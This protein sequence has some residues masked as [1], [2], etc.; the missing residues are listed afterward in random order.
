MH[1]RDFLLGSAAGALAMGV[2]RATTIRSSWNAVK[3]E[4]DL[5]PGLVH[6]SGF[7]LATHPSAVR[8]AIAKHRR[9]LDENPLWYLEEQMR[10]MEPAVRASA[11]EYM[12][13]KEEGIAFTDS[14]TMGLGLVYGG[15]AMRPGQEILSTTHDHIAASA[16][17]RSSSMA[18]RPG[19][20]RARS[21]RRWRP[22]FAPRPA[23]SRS[24]GCTPA[25]A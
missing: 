3:A 22:R 13:V 18:I 16:S 17:A 9:G 10:T 21:R 4:F 8:D 24:P 19:R 5:A 14:T 23:S 6:M 11:A 15:L 2:A 25:R 7:F 20:R 12:G 1:R